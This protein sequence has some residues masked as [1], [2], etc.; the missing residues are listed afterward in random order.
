M[1]GGEHADISR[2]ETGGYAANSS[3]DCQ[4]DFRLIRKGKLEYIFQAGWT[5]DSSLFEEHL[6]GLVI[7]R[8]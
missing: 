2:C 7:G 1:H 5:T 4:K 8:E 6:T 3:R